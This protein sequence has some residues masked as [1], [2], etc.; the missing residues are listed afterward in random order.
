[1]INLKNLFAVSSESGTVQENLTPINNAKN[2]SETYKDYGFRLAGLSQGSNSV[3]P[4]CLQSVC[5]GIKQKQAEDTA[6]QQQ[7]QQ[8]LEG[9]K[10]QLEVEQENKKNELA[11]C[12]QNQNDINGEIAA[13]KAKITQLDD[14]KYN[15]NRDAWI[16]FIITAVILIP[17]TVYFFIFYSS[18]AYSAFFDQFDINTMTGNTLAKAIF[19][20]HAIPN[21]L[22]DGVGELLFILFMPIIFLAF[23]FVLNRWERE[24]GFLKYLK[25]PSLIFVAFTFDALLAYSITKKLYYLAAMT[26]LGDVPPYTPSLAIAD[27]DFWVVICLGFVSYLIWGFVF[28]YFIKSWESLDL[29]VVQ[30]RA[31]EEN[32]GKLTQDLNTEKQKEIDLKSQLIDLGA[33]ISQIVARMNGG[34]VRY[35]MDKLKLELNNFFAGWQTYLSVLDRSNGEKEEAQEILNKMVNSLNTQE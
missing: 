13:T 14:S 34:F 26:E 12:Q 30:K 16:T 8:K 33:R 20:P 11:A 29:S 10:S 21:A 24:S 5:L 17:F 1:M 23:G 31:L 4:S 7:L 28:G 32:L 2:E 25:I 6:L 3:L 27:P 15:R 35:D 18:V 9:E 19:N 22:S